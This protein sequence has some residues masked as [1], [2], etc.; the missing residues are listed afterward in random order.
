VIGKGLKINSDE[1]LGLLKKLYFNQLPFFERTQAIV[2]RMMPGE[3]NS[4]Y[5]FAYKTAQGH[6]ENGHSVGWVMGWVEENKHPYFFVLNLESTD[7]AKDLQQTGLVI[8]K[9]ILRQLGLFA[10]KK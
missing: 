5:R 10:G 8:A 2:R 9:Q 3:R 6:M 7:P 4:A 1:Q